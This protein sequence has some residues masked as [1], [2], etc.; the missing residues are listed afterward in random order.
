MSQHNN[1]NKE[2]IHNI[3]IVRIWHCGKRYECAKLCSTWSRLNFTNYQI[4][5]LPTYYG[6]YGIRYNAKEN[7]F[8]FSA[9]I[10][11]LPEVTIIW[12]HLQS[13]ESDAI[14]ESIICIAENNSAEDKYIPGTMQNINRCQSM[15][16]KLVFHINSLCVMLMT[17]EKWLSLQWIFPTIAN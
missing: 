10:K 15:V 13:L 6:S 16:V 7:T 5:Y 1:R 11:W 3:S 4:W 17:Y 14:I 12:F 2:S 8:A 9:L